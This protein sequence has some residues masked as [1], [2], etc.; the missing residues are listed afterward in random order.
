MSSGHL[1]DRGV[2]N[3]NGPNALDRSKGLERADNRRH[4]GSLAHGKADKAHAKR[5]HHAAPTRQA[6]A[7]S[8]ADR[9]AFALPRPHTSPLPGRSNFP[10]PSTP[11]LP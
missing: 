5:K 6:P 8:H 11:R 10:A 7:L 4:A 3:S 1:S 2:R 9:D